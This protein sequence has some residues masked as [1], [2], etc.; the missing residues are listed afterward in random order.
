MQKDGRLLVEATVSN[1]AD[2]R[3]WLLGFGPGVEV[4]GPPSLRKSAIWSS[5]SVFSQAS[6]PS[7][8]GIS[9]A[10]CIGTVCGRAGADVAV[11]SA[12]AWLSGAAV[13]C[14]LVVPLDCLAVVSVDGVVGDGCSAAGAVVGSV[15]G[16]GDVSDDAA[17]SA[18]GPQAMAAMRNSAVRKTTPNETR[19]IWK[20]ITLLTGKHV[21]NRDTPAARVRIDHRRAIV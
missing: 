5:I 11:G 19:R 16:A 21:S 14:S 18:L 20:G 2:L 9:S 17:G 1:N 3:W 8:A 13:G 15:A 4:L 10:D 7:M 12:A 6:I